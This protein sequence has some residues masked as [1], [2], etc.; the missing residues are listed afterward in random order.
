MK[1]VRTPKAPACTEI[2]KR[3]LADECPNVVMMFGVYDAH[4]FRDKEVMDVLIACLRDQRALDSVPGLTPWGT[5]TTA[6][7]VI[8]SRLVGEIRRWTTGD[9]TARLESPSGSRV[10][11]EWWKRNRAIYD[12]GLSPNTWQLLG[13]WNGTCRKS[14][15][16]VFALPEGRF[17]F[18]VLDYKEHW[19]GDRP[20]NDLTLSFWREGEDPAKCGSTCAK[21]R[22]DGEKGSY[23][24]GMFTQRWMIEHYVVPDRDG[25][26]RVALRVWKAK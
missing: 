24:L 1:R 7:D 16:M 20:V 13:E 10:V 15:E 18:A 3:L 17:H 2:A 4:D 22:E 5:D 21:L 6:A 26:F 9:P 8:A 23:S 25:A 19:L 11:R 12:Y 14:E